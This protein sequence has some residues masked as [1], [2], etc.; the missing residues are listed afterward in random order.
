MFMYQSPKLSFITRER[1]VWQEKARFQNCRGH[2]RATRVLAVA[3]VSG[4]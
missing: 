4:L 3:S 2:K 1:G